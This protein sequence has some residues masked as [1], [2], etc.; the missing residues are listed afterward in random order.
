MKSMKIEIQLC[1]VREALKED[2]RGVLREL[3]KLG[4]ELLI[5][6]QDACTCPPLKSAGLSLTFLRKFL[7]K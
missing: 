4:C 1:T 5:C 6:E 2:Y 7:S 3:A